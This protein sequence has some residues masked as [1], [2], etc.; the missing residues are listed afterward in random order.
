[1][2]RG[3]SRKVGYKRKISTRARKTEKIR[4]TQT[5]WVLKVMVEVR[6]KKERA[7]NAGLGGVR[8]RSRESRGTRKCPNKITVDWKMLYYEK[9]M[10]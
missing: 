9:S 10:G 5:T 7:P 3:P 6:E 1:M 2:K 8:R 4:S